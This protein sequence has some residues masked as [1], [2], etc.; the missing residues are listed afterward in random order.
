MFSNTESSNPA[1]LKRRFVNRRRRGFSLIE[2]VVVILILGVIAAV[3]APRM[4]DTADDAADNSTR[5]TLAVIRNAIEIYRVKHSTYPP[6]TNSAE[7]KD[8]LRPYLNAPIPAPACL[9]N[10]NSDVVEDDSAGFEAVPNDEDP[11]SWVYKPATGSFKL[12]SN[13]ATHL[14]W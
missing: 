4:F 12:N 2:L 14:T 9:P 10:A 5:Q 8:A 13:D 7:F 11:A 1:S 3:A 6:I